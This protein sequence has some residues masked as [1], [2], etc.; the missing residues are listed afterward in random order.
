MD[1][2]VV[3]TGGFDPVHSGH[4]SYLSAAR[5]L[6]D[7]LMVGINSDAWLQRKKG[8]VFMPWSERASVISNLRFVDRVIDFDDSDGSGTDAIRIIQ[9]M[10][11]W[12]AIIFANGGDRTAETSVEAQLPGVEYV[13]GVGGT[14][15]LNSSSLIVDAVRKKT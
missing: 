15:K 5:Q 6:G 10:F 11:P 8:Y 9:T 14:D 4:I 1:R 7:Y 3:A 12:T 2:I 13:Y